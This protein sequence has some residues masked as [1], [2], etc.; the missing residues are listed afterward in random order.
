M[1]VETALIFQYGPAGIQTVEVSWPCRENAKG[2]VR[3]LNSWQVLKGKH[4]VTIEVGY[5]WK[6][7]RP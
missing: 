6:S 5:H 7:T 2:K 1:Q 3:H 4:I